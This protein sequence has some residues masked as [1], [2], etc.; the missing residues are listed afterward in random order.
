MPLLVNPN[1]F[2]EEVLRSRL[3][4]LL[5]FFG[6]RCAP[7]LFLRPILLELAG[8]FAG[9]LKI[10]MLNTDR[11]RRDSDEDYDEKFR[12]LEEYG[13]RHLPTLLL[14]SGGKLRQ[15]VVGLRTKEELLETLSE[16]GLTPQPHPGGKPRP[17]KRKHGG[18]DE[19]GDD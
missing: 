15:T 14:F 8:D 7:C 1:N 16:E 10:C 12:I 9:Q 19:E 17:R 4:V 5:D 13:V 2:E 3:P 6:E 11:E 18:K